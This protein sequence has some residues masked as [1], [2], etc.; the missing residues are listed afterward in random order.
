MRAAK[1]GK[2][3][4]VVEGYSDKRFFLGL[5]RHIGFPVA[6]DVTFPGDLS[7]HPGKDG[8]IKTFNLW[9]EEAAE[10][11]RFESI[12]ICID[13]D[14]APESGFL[15]TEK[16]LKRLLAA[17]NFRM[18]DADCNLY[19]HISSGCKASYWVAPSHGTDGYL[20]SLA[21]G[22]L[23]DDEAEYIKMTIQPFIDDLNPARF[24]SKNTDRA[25]LY[26][27]LATQRKPDK[28]LPTLLDDQKIDLAKNCLSL[29]SQWLK[30]LFG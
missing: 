30:N 18:V 7:R 13:A 3:M 8:A 19:H 23:K 15:E 9:L 14:F 26:I 16:N 2:R 28:S 5:Q 20:E 4:L 22:S 12:G 6:F 1:V 11:G 25:A 27:Y 17:A 24:E 29:L 10:P 21:L